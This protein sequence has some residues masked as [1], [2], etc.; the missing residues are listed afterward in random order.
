MISSEPFKLW[1]WYDTLAGK[2]VQIIEIN[3]TPGYETVRG[4]DMLHRAGLHT[5]GWRYNRESDRG[6][7]TGSPDD[8]PNNLIPNPIPA[9]PG[10]PSSLV[11]RDSSVDRWTFRE[12]F[13]LGEIHVLEG[14]SVRDIV[15]EK[16]AISA[17]LLQRK[18]LLDRIDELE[19]EDAGNADAIGATVVPTRYAGDGRECID[20]IRDVM[21]WW[22]GDKKVAMS[23]D[24]FVDGHD[25][26]H[27]YCVGQVIRYRFR[28]GLKGPAEEDEAKAVWY[29]RMALH[30]ATPEKH[31]DP[32]S[33][34]PGFTPYVY[35]RPSDE[36]LNRIANM[37]EAL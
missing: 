1:G 17:L 4:D 33:E 13:H 24:D 23:R 15:H 26:F 10:V 32:R 2:R 6:R 5:S 11:T 37:F 22:F 3:N 12:S 25:A 14:D 34:R 21:V 31:L 29:E 36:D 35:V 30:V 20:L 27:G 7:C 18:V 9:S 19:G 16:A 28:K 8:C